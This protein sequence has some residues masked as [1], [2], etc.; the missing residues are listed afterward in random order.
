MLADMAV[1]LELS[2]LITYKSASD[3]DNG[4]RSS[5]NASIAKCFA[6]DTANIAATNAVQVNNS[7]SN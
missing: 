6:S 5:Y 3:V 1:N 7:F 2:R 4:V